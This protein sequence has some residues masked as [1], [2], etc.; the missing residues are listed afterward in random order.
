MDGRDF[1]PAEV[2]RPIRLC[3]VI[4]GF[5]ALMACV[6]V[7]VTDW[8]GSAYPAA[9]AC[10]VVLAICVAGCILLKTRW[11]RCALVLATVNLVAVVPELCLRAA[12]FQYVSE[13][14]FLGLRPHARVIFEPDDELFWKY[15]TSLP[16]VNSFGFRGREVAV[17]KDANVRRLLFLG[18][19]CTD[20]DFARLV[21]I[22]LNGDPGRDSLRYECVVLAAPGY[23][24]YQGK[25][26]ASKYAGLLEADLA[27]VCFGWNDHWLAYG[28]T[29]EVAGSMVFRNVLS[30]ANHHSRMLQ[31]GMKLI[32]SVFGCREQGVIDEVRVPAGQFESNLATI[33]SL[34]DA[35]GVP[36]VFVTAPAAHSS[37][38]VPQYLLERRY[39]PSAQFVLNKHSEYCA[40][41]RAV[42]RR[43]GAKLLD[44]EKELAALERPDE[45]FMSDGIHFSRSGLHVMATRI[46]RFVRN[47]TGLVPHGHG[48]AEFHLAVK[49]P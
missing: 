29:D 40:I 27:F 18:D 28:C 25:V 9:V 16:D 48:D 24:S 1:D 12:D 8:S 38:G 22:L 10:I 13:V 4:S 47:E 39:A 14:S 23:S 31:A 44:L 34:F 35:Q 2:R 19:S 20:Q 49:G 37:Q 43:C 17:P 45:L 3:L 26:L 15:P 33:N 42:A 41:V 6:F 21:E 32:H 30:T 46:Y 5:I 11:V 36:V 7:A